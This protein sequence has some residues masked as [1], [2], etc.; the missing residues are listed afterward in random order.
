M[1]HKCAGCIH[2]PY[3]MGDPQLFKA[4]T[5]LAM[6]HKRAGCLHNFYRV[7]GP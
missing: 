7:G 3:R 6:A 5:K 4:K 1:D 2:N